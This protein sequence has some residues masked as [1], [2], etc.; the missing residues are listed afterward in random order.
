MH[1]HTEMI[2]FLSQDFVLRVT[3]H[4]AE[5]SVVAWQKDFET[6]HEGWEKVRI[7]MRARARR[8]AEPSLSGLTSR[9]LYDIWSD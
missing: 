2:E 8:F 1:A 5:E 6:I 3:E 7:R 4:A 9:Y